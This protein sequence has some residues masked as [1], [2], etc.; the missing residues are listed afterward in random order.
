MKADDSSSSRARSCS[1]PTRRSTVEAGRC[2]R[3]SSRC[4]R[5]PVRDP[6]GRGVPRARRGGRTS[7][8]DRRQSRRHLLRQHVRPA[9]AQALGEESLYLHEATPG[10][11]FQIALQRELDDLPMFRRFAARP[12]I[13]KAGACTPNRSARSS[14]STPIRTSTSAP[15]GRAVARDPPRRRHRPALQGLDARAGDRV[16]ARE[17]AR[18]SRPRRLRS[19]ALHRHPG[20]GAGVQD[21]RAQDQELRKRAEKALGEKFDIREFHAEVLK[22]GSCRWT[23]SRRRSIAGSR[24]RADTGRSRPARLRRPTPVPQTR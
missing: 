6:S 14:A 3:R 4:S 23:C 19:R 13:A 7:P 22:D 1:P 17:L 18:R 11:H 2:C 21:R 15:A 8:V 16:H 20:P 10:H 5:R 9:V 24:R 12:R